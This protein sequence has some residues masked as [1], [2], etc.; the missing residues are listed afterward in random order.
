V[1]LD[2]SWAA[3]SHRELADAVATRTHSRLVPLLC[4]APSAIADARIRARTGTLSDADTVVATRMAV[5]M[6]PWP[7]AT[8]VSTVDSQADSLT[9]A[10]AAL[11][12][13]L[14]RKLRLVT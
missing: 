4:Q 2:A 8:V 1:V 3:Q 9:Q 10:S 6:D 11:A 7:Q 14:D 12:T 13:P 5:E